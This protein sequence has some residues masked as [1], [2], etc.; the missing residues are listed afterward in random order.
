M[1]EQKTDGLAVKLLK[2]QESVAAVVKRGQNTEQ[3]YSY[4]TA[5]DV[6]DV[7]R[8]AL[9]GAG[10]VSAIT[11]VDVTARRPFE[12]KN[13]TKGLHVEVAVKLVVIDP[14]SD[15]EQAFIAVGAGAD[16]G[17]G[18][19]APLKAQ[20]AATKYAYANALA[21]PFADHD[22]EKDVAGEPGRLPEQKPDPEKALSEERVKE[23]LA[24]VKSAE[25]G[26]SDLTTLMGAAGAEGP[27][28]KRKDSIRKAIASMTEQ[29][30]E[31]FLSALDARTNPNRQGA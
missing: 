12:T 27:A 14:D 10:L 7:S 26:F 21:L 5:A 3:R 15:Q 22:P 11:D 23:I 16:Y 6:I 4:A 9:H 13:K 30:A 24:A 25:L 28:I 17:G 18:D 8:K 29:Q 20:T 1:S 2:A 31:F 19:K